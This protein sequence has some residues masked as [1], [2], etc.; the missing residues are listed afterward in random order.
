MEMNLSRA[1]FLLHFLTL[2]HMDWTHARSLNR[3]A[4]RVL[5]PDS[6]SRVL[7]W[8]LVIPRVCS[9]SSSMLA[10]GPAGAAAILGI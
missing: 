1:V 5:K 9:I 4:W 7:V 2:L 8:T 10:G 3:R 6:M